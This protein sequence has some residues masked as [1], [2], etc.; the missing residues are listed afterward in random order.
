MSDGNVRPFQNNK[1]KP[2][3]SGKAKPKLEMHVSE[4]HRAIDTGKMIF[5]KT[6]TEERIDCAVIA[7]DRYFLKI[8]SDEGTVKL[9]NKG[10]IEQ[11]DL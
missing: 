7:Q 1:R 11:I 3:K 10:A 2:N 8:R 9:I 4:I 5:I 6:I